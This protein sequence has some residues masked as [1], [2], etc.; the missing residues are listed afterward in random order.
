MKALAARRTPMYL[1]R[2]IDDYL[3]QRTLIYDTDDGPVEYRITA[4]VPQGSVLG[5][6]LWNVMYDGLLELE[7]PD[8]SCIVGFADDAGIV[9]TAIS[10]QTLEIIANECLRRASKWMRENGLAI[11]VQKTEALLITDKRIF[12]PPSLVLEGQTVPWSK[13]LRYLGVQ[14]DNGMK[15]TEHIK[16]IAEKASTT[17]AA[18]ARLMPNIGGP[19]ECKRRLL[20]S[21]IHSKILHAAEIWAEALVKVRTRRR[22]ASVQRRSALRV[23]SAYRTVS[24]AAVLV[25]ASTPPIDLLAQEK[26]E[27][28]NEFQEHR[29]KPESGLIKC[30]IKKETR[31]RMLERW[32]ADRK[33]VV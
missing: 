2:M 11:S 8:A 7:L 18:L 5:P 16:N 23:I 1:L 14:L 9:A 25:L 28:Y 27:T 4:G 32:Q 31:K 29:G 33:S 17:A 13:S 26:Q 6:F 21:V 22:L 12:T 20:N 19:K 3:A 15:Y 24:E 30:K 10:T